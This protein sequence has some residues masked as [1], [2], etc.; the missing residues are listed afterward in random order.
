MARTVDLPA[1]GIRPI[2][3]SGECEVDLVRRELRVHG[4]PVPIG[5]R[6]F[7][8][9]E[10]LVRSAGELVTKD[11]LMDQLWPGAVV[12]ENALQVL[13]GATRKAL[14]P[15]RDL[16]RTEARRGYRL[17]GEWTVQ[18][19]NMATRPV[20][21]R[22]TG[23]A[24]ELA[25][26]NFPA[27]V[28][29]L[30]GRLAALQTL[31][32][33]IS[34]YRAVTLTGPGGIGKT[35]L[36]LDLARRVHGE[37]AN[38]GWLV[39]LASLSDPNLVPAAVASVLGLRLESSTISPEAVGRAIAQKNF[40]L[41]L[42]NCEHLIDATATL[43]E[44]L[45]RLCPRVTILATSREIFR[46]TGE[47]AYPVPPLEVPAMGRDEP[48]HILSQ[49]AVE[50]F[51]ARTNA[52][53]PD[54]TP[55][56]ANLPAI[57][58]IC[59]HLDG[60]PLAIEFAAGHAATLGPEHVADGLRDRIALLASGRRATIPR[61]RTLRAALDWSYELLPEREQRLMRHL[62]IFSGGFTLP[63]AAAVAGDVDGIEPRIADGIASLVYKSLITRDRSAATPRWY[64]LETIRAYALEKLA[65]QDEIETAAR[66]HAA[67]YRDL[68]ASRRLDGD[69]PGDDM[70]LF[71]R[72]IDNV[73][74]A[75]D[76]CFSSAGYAETGVI[77]TAAYVPAW[78]RAAL[79]TECSERTER[80]MNSLTPGMNV[81]VP[82]LM[83]L[84]F[85]FGLMPAF[86]M[87]PV[88]PAKA[89]LNKA[90]TLAEQIGDL[91]A[92]FQ[93]LWG[94]WVL[95]CETA[96]S[97][98]TFSVTEQLS[99][100]ARRIGDPSAS[101][102]A[103]RLRGFVLE[104]QGHHQ[105][106]RECSEHVVRHWVPPTDR[107]LTAW[108]QFDQRVLARAMLARTL[109]FQGYADQ[110]MN[111]ARLSLEEAQR[112]NLPLSIGEAL[113][114]AVC[115]IALMTGDLETADQSITML[116]EVATSRNAPFW[117]I[118]GRCFRGK[119]L[120]ARGEFAEGCARLR[121]EL[122]F[123]ERANWPIWYP[124]F[125]GAMAEGLGGLG[126]VGEAL[127]AVN[128]GLA[129]ADHGGE[130]YHYPEL[131]RLRGELLLRQ[132]IAQRGSDAAQSFLS[133]L[134]LARQQGAL[135]SELRAAVGLARLRVTQDRY[136][137][138]KQI[139]TPVYHRFTE[140]FDTSDLIAARE[141]LSMLR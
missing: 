49:S 53:A 45:M 13:A 76:W 109:W 106:A 25:G 105:E 86:T 33:L 20:G 104:M 127:A 67:F 46:I 8:F 117:G 131:L 122:E 26:T 51:I 42:D 29:P 64:L 38:G 137:E 85:A 66:R 71:T 36:A 19:R 99:L 95:N 3:A 57:A 43:A 91:Q 81:S 47:Y 103:Q 35:V 128:K 15:Y 62:A 14:G 30:I 133:A 37:F 41:V 113:R 55:H 10:V 77:L 34:A 16:L 1:K 40:L 75:L 79:P 84:H 68:F 129:S 120:V 125:I 72:E 136:D 135:A 115:G 100:V 48:E 32:A 22:Q 78:L 92:Q 39:E 102:M 21:L 83:Q 65:V 134:C 121:T 107:R 7:D 98:T 58:T 126:L 9:V 59:R 114:V 101:L 12:T 6:A 27:A 74:A 24:D 111:Q 90:L 11:E 138:A 44:T 61:H 88:Q 130:R 73:R 70:G 52:L 118:L 69:A 132:P 97:H 28:T 17:L 96:E 2:Y 54:F 50:L 82:L 80:A 4:T 63:A 123:C 93:S 60:I 112:T 119:L 110:A 18:R 31:Q 108:G 141:L 87:S 5:G 89:A 94:L 23:I 140:G 124:E 139:L 56:A 116:I